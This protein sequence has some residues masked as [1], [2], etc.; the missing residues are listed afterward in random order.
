MPKVDHAREERIQQ[1][2][3]KVTPGSVSVDS[4]TVASADAE[5]ARGAHEEEPQMT[6]AIASDLVWMER[7]AS[8]LVLIHAAS[9]RFATLS[10]WQ[11]CHSERIIWVSPG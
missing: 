11:K 8:E 9:K 1:K 6:S 3:L 7:E 5:A 10:A 2:K 4:S